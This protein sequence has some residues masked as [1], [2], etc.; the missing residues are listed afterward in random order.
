MHNRT[1]LYTLI[2]TILAYVNNSLRAYEISVLDEAQLI[3]YQ[4]RLNDL[5]RF[6]IFIYDFR[7]KVN[8]RLFW[9]MIRMDT[10][11]PL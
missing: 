11:W 3:K 1:M 4:T 7:Y 10:H 2:A 9:I 6:S 8:F 5:I